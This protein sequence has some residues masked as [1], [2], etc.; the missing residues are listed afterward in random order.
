MLPLPLMAARC[1]ICGKGPKAG[2][3]VSHSVRRTK[4]RWL[5]NLHKMKIDRNG[6]IKRAKVCSACLKANKVTK[7]V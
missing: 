7:V 4:R 6:S 1:D 2:H 3:N 5:P